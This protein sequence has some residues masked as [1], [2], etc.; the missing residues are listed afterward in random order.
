M[1]NLFSRFDARMRMR[2]QSIDSLGKTPAFF[3]QAW[4]TCSIRLKVYLKL[5]IS[6][7]QNIEGGHEI[8]EFHLE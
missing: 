6:K 7:I 2:R 4:W 8:N 1:I 3:E 5:F